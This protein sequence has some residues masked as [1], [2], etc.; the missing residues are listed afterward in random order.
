MK[1]IRGDVVLTRFPHAGGTRGKKQ[2][3]S[4]NRK[5]GHVIVT[6]ITHNLAPADDPASLCVLCP[7]GV[8]IS[9][10]GGRSKLLTLT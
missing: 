5:V 3:D 7:S 9:E 6:E 4:Y 10:F 2:A 1:L 8:I